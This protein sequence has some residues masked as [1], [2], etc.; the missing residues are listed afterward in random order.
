MKIKI[1]NNFVVGLNHLGKAVFADR[2]YKK[3]SV[4]VKFEGPV[5]EKEGLPKNLKGSMDRYVQIGTNAFMGP[6]D[7]VDDYINHS[8]DPN[9]G[10]RFSSVG[11]ILVAIKPIKKG[12]EITWDYSTTLY[13]NSWK[14]ECHCHSPNCRKIIREFKFLP[15]QTQIKYIKLNVVPPYIVRDFN[16]R[17]TTNK[18]A[19]I[20]GS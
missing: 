1:F 17:D 19:V 14:M 20:I 12:E 8:C 4:I 10:L 7:T 18:K 11:I 16:R 6:S 3:D 9:A 2:D 5:T 15:K 13:K